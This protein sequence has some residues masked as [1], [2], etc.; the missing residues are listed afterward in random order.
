MTTTHDGAMRTDNKRL[1]SW[2]DD[3]AKLCKPD[4]IYWC[5][6]SKEEYNRFCDEMVESGVFTRLNPDKRPN[7]FLAR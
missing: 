7:S 5:D 1:L 6:G 4:R 2:V 3:M